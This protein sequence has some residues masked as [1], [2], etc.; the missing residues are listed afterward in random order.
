M[1]LDIT[2]K[3]YELVFRIVSSLA[4]NFSHGA[5]RSCQFY[6]VNGAIIL[7]EV[8]KI[9][10]RPVMGAAFIRLNKE[11]DIV[12][13]AGNES[14]NFYSSTDFFHCWIETPNF[15]IDFTAPEYSKS[16]GNFLGSI[17]IKMFQKSKGKMSTNPNSLF[18]PGDFFFE[19]NKE[20]TA[21][22]LNKMVS[23]PVMA[24]FANICLEWHKKC[25]KN[26]LKEMQIMNDLGRI[27]RI[28]LKPGNISSSW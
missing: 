22:F 23:N 18:T 16:E 2:L 25:K 1:K 6:N 17:P 3:Q 21:H 12:A 13:Y 19:E 10:A 26:V 15:L 5:G 9:R 27:T 4:E 20:L 28:K 24:D 7:N 14:G 8:L 11:G